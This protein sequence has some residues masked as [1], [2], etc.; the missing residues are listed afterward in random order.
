MNSFTKTL[1]SEQSTMKELALAIKAGA[2]VIAS[3]G[4][5]W[6]VLLTAFFATACF[7]KLVRATATWQAPAGGS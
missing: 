5:L 1:K 6:M 3:G 7:A 4:C 2:E